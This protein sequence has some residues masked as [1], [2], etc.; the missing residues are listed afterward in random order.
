MIST[1]NGPKLRQQGVWSPYL[2]DFV[3]TF[4][5]QRDQQERAAYPASSLLE[6]EFFDGVKENSSLYEIQQLLEDYHLQKEELFDL[7]E[8]DDLY[9]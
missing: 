5:L 4:C 1:E 2:Y 9:I 7:T 3:D 8:F 6:H